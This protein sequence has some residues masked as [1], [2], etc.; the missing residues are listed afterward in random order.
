MGHN[1]LYEVPCVLCPGFIQVLPSSWDSSP[2]QLPC[3]SASPWVEASACPHLLLPRSTCQLCVHLS[4]RGQGGLGSRWALQTSPYCMCVCE[5]MQPSSGTDELQTP[6]AGPL[7]DRR[8][9]S[10]CGPACHPLPSTSARQ[11]R[12]L[13]PQEKGEGVFP[14]WRMRTGSR[15]V[16]ALGYSLGPQ[17]VCAGSGAGS[18]CGPSPSQAWQSWTLQPWWYCWPEA[19]CLPQG[20]HAG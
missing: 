2:H 17:G 1:D 6:M 15:E 13:T 14:L 8:H 11:R 19:L 9:G 18:R 12:A 10:H 7:Y 3:L 5:Y 20:L 16:E 4:R